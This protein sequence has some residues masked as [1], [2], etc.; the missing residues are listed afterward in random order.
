MY[1]LP[2][3]VVP[4]SRPGFYDTESATTIEQTAKVYKAMQDLIT[5]YNTFA[6]NVNK[7]IEDFISGSNEEYNTFKIAIR[8][9][10]QDFIDVI[11]LKIAEQDKIISDKS[12]ELD[13]KH[14]SF[15]N[16]IQKIQKA[17]KT[18]IENSLS[19]FEQNVDTKIEIFE[20]HINSI[21]SDAVL[22]M[23]TNL[24]TTISELI[25]EMRD[26]G[27]LTN[28]IMV[29]FNDIIRNLSNEIESREQQY[30]VLSARMNA[31]EQLEEGSTTGDAELMDA[32]VDFQGVTHDSAG[33]SIRHQAKML[34][35]SVNGIPLFMMNETIQ[36]FFEPIKQLI[37]PV[38]VDNGFY[39]DK[40]KTEHQHEETKQFEYPASY[41]DVFYLTSNDNWEMSR[42][43]I[44][45]SEGNVID[46]EKGE[47]SDELSQNTLIECPYNTSKIVFQVSDNH[48]PNFILY[49]V[50]GYELKKDS[51]SF[52]KLKEESIHLKNL[53]MALQ[54]TFTSKK[55]KEMEV[56]FSQHTNCY[57]Q[58]NGIGAK[59]LY[60]NASS[61]HAYSLID[62]LPDDI[63]QIDSAHAWDIA[64]FITL[65]E[66]MNCVRH[67]ELQ[68]GAYTNAVVEITIQENE[69]YLIVNKYGFNSLSEFDSYAIESEGVNNNKL[70][71]KK[72]VYDGDSICESRLN[73][74]AI[75]GGGYAKIIADLTNGYYVNQAVGGGTITKNDNGHSVVD[76]LSNLPTDADLYCFE[77]GINDFW[78]NRLLGQTTSDYSS[79]LDTTTFCGA[80]E[81]IFRY[82]IEH[83]VGKPICFVITHKVTDTSWIPNRNG[84]T[85]TDF[86]DKAIEIC[87][88]YSIPF[89]DAFNESGLN[90][91]NEVQKNQFF[92]QNDGIGDGCHPIEIGYR[93]FY[94]PQLIDLF[95]RIIE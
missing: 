22:Y 32:R 44:L 74:D 67:D 85:F 76:N 88:K 13:E 83:F 78:T 90:G 25:I 46:S 77:G 38:W 21:I 80:L 11:D 89:Y 59:P 5:E 31:F 36:S 19:L 71:G 62:V 28:D 68:A 72:I 18:E 45:D 93:K 61:D 30:Q 15:T 86:H 53:E 54:K 39:F 29:V 14:T 55:F 94:V 52:E 50:I 79:A 4:N 81:Y 92:R 75:N 33:E 20:E 84:N 57:V 49:K 17:F 58:F 48:L 42:Y 47:T 66:N 7:I 87:R 40:D 3:W 37:P 26:N 43:L 16:S 51:I 91:W 65:D 6:T 41:G 2:L 63:Y 12:K 27:E 23:K 35:D 24:H 82:A 69:K 60:V 70:Q 1:Q 9:E 73:G 56:D 95:N 10:F 64:L 8:Q 34:Y